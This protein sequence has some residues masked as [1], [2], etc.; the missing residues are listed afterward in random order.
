MTDLVFYEKPG[1]V[2]NA[3]QKAE[4]RSQGIEVQERDLLSEPWTLSSLRAFFGNTP[5]AEWFNLSAPA[6]KTGQVNIHD[7]TE[8]EA[9]SQML[10]SP[11]LI[12][13]PLLA[14]GDVRQSGYVDGPVLDALGV[15]LKP[16]EDLQS[17]PMGDAPSECAVPAGEPA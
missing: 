14:L 4:L 12:R 3:Q 13:R 5:V 1:C 8:A 9:L 7:C 2:G 15:Q 6:V 16:G 10:A 17:C 11:L